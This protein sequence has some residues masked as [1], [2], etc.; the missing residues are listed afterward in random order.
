MTKFRLTSSR[1]KTLWEFNPT[2]SEGQPDFV[3]A[4]TALGGVRAIARPPGH[5]IF[6]VLPGEVLIELENGKWTKL[7]GHAAATLLVET[8]ELPQEDLAGSPSD[9]ERL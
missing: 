5:P 7:D 1:I 6:Y 9:S 8:T 4:S 3:Q 2:T